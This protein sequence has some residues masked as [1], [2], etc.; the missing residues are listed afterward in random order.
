[1]QEENNTPSDLDKKKII[2]KQSCRE[3]DDVN[4]DASLD[5]P[6]KPSVE[7]L[8]RRYSRQESEARVMKLLEEKSS[9]DKG[10]VLKSEDKDQLTSEWQT[11]DGDDSQPSTEDDETHETETLSTDLMAEIVRKDAD[12]LYIY[13]NFK[14]FLRDCG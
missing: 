8:V 10:R 14:D 3:S 1:M 9:A 6:D 12:F 7:T 13:T 2:E 5:I 11:Q 4:E